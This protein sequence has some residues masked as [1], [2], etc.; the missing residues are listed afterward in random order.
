MYLCPACKR[1]VEAKVNSRQ[2]RRC[3]A[4]Y[5]LLADKDRIADTPPTPVPAPKT[6]DEEL[7]RPARARRRVSRLGN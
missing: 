6:T 3:S 4:C 2:E 7:P 1:T 5:G